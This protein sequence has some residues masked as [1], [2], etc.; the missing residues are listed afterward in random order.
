VIGGD[1][2]AKAKRVPETEAL[3]AEL[4]FLS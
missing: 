2:I 4:R 3:W 1:T